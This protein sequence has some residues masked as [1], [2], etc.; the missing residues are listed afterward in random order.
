MKLIFFGGAEACNKSRFVGWVH[1]C[2][3]VK[4]FLLF[5]LFL[6]LRVKLGIKK[7]NKESFGGTRN[8]LGYRKKPPRIF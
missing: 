4:F 1:G 6:H 2:T 8:V 3:A 5:F 7:V